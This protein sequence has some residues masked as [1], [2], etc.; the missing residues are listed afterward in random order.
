MLIRRL[1][2]I[3]LPLRSSIRIGDFGTAVTRSPALGM[4]ALR[5]AMAPFSWPWHPLLSQGTDAG[6]IESSW[7]P[8]PSPVFPGAA[9][10]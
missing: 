2:S 5:L 4:A 6:N 7:V 1:W 8:W 3:G 9:M 10:L